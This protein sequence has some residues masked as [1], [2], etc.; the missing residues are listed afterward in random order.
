MEIK[1][2]LLI[3]LLIMFVI[4]LN[5]RLNVFNL[6]FYDKEFSKL[7]IYNNIP[8][9]IAFENTKTLINY[10]NKDDKLEVGFFN[11]KEI[12]HLKDVKHLINKSIILFYLI[13]ILLII[14]ITIN[15][16]F[17]KVFF[18]SGILL[19]LIPLILLF[20]DFNSV[21]IKFHEIFFNNNLWLLNPE[22]DNLIKLFPEQFFID[23]VKKTFINSAIIGLLLFASSFSLKK[24]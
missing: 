20:F 15:K 18:Y 8:K 21:F 1:K 11:E 14:F 19:V 23:F 12:L 3:L 2:L 17:S 6:K 9:E 16:D 24:D 5:F 4:L 10:F 7:E 13:L 22:T